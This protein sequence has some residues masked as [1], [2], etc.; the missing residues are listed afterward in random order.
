MEAFLGEEMKYQILSNDMYLNKLFEANN[1]F[2]ESKI[3]L[4][5]IFEKVKDIKNITRNYL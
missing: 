3:S 5:E 1:D 2:K 4:S